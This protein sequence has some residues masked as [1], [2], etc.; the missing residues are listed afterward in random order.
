MVKKR[1]SKSRQRRLLVMGTASIIAFV[2]LCVNIF[3]YSYKI[4]KLTKK[5]NELTQELDLLKIEKERLDVEIQK[6][7]NEQ[8]ISE[9][10]RKNY[11]YSKNGEYVIRIQEDNKELEKAVEEINK[12]NDSKKYILALSIGASVLLILFIRTKKS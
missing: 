6:L 12:I 2:F 9:Y 7:Q 11:L 1:I 10:I 3:N 8:Y 4:V 5:Q